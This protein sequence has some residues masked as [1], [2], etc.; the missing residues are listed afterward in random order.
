MKGKLSDER[1]YTLKASTV[2]CSETTAMGRVVNAINQLRSAYC[3]FEE[4]D[5]IFVVCAPSVTK[6][7]CR[8][9][10]ASMRRSVD[11]LLEQEDNLAV[12]REFHS[13]L[14]V[15]GVRL[16]PDDSIPEDT[17]EAVFVAILNILL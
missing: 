5:S 15:E 8:R 16:R 9:W 2:T 13:D 7:D 6:K 17:H 4:G 1:F 3:A 11:T 14:G 12:T 10:I